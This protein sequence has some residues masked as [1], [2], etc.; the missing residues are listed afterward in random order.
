MGYQEVKDQIQNAAKE[1]CRES[2]EITLVAVSKT[3]PWE[4]IKPIYGQGCV[5]FGENRLQ[6]ALDKQKNAPK[7]IKWHLIGTLQRNKVAK[8]IGHFSLIHSVDSLEL[9]KKIDACSQVADV[10]TPI[11]LQVNVSKEAS[12]HGFNEESIKAAFADLNDLKHIRIEGLMTMAPI[13]QEEKVVRPCFVHLRN[14]RDELKK[15]SGLNLPHLSMGMSQDFYWAVLEG[16]T[17]VRVGS[18]I[19]D[20]KT[21]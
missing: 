18:A 20:S 12:K 8:A 13:S 14:L 11:L 5:D 21:N 4:E 16:A 3:K 19:F 9:A 6:E 17:L 1:A 10:T 7:E 15:R 2:S